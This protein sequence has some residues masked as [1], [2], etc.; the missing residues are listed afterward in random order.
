MS[1]DSITGIG[2]IKYTSHHFGLTFYIKSSHL[3]IMW[4]FSCL[5]Y[6]LIIL[7]HKG[8]ILIK[9]LKTQNKKYGN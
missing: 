6:V 8:T 7:N 3:N 1:L 5:V 9:P 4:K 2:V